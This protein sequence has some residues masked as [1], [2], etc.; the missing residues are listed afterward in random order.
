MESP[1]T[2]SAYTIKLA[3]SELNASN[4]LTM[5]AEN[6]GTIPPNT[7]Y[8]VVM[9]GENRYDARLESTEGSSAMVRFIKK[10]GK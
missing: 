5:V 8:M 1:I 9:V 3:V 7:S 6:L 4:E 10:P 2:G